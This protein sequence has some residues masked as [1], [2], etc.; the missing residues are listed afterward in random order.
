M[1]S[2][3]KSLTKLSEPRSS[4]ARSPSISFGSATG[5]DLESQR[6]RRLVEHPAEEPLIR[7]TREADVLDAAR[8]EDRLQLRDPVLHRVFRTETERRDRLVAG[9]PVVTVVLELHVG[10]LDLEVGELRLQAVGQVGDL[11]V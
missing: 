2:K 3:V 4:I 9:H 6:R 5:P 7:M 10:P 8:L 11:H 1:P